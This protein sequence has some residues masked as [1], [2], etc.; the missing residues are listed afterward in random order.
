MTNIEFRKFLSLY[1][2]WHDA[3][4][5]SQEW[6]NEKAW[7]L[8]NKL[9]MPKNWILSS[10]EEEMQKELIRIKEYNFHFLLDEI[11]SNLYQ[12]S[13]D[14]RESYIRELIVEFLFLY[15]Y[16]S[17]LS[18]DEGEIDPLMP[19][20]TIVPG[21]NAVIAL[22]KEYKSTPEKSD[23]SILKYIL[24]CLSKYLGFLE[25]L[26]IICIGIGVDIEHIQEKFG[27]IVR[28]GRNYSSLEID[29][30][31]S[32]DY[33]KEIEIKHKKESLLNKTDTYISITHS[34][35]E[36]YRNFKDIFISEDAYNKA[37][38]VLGEYFDG[39][40]PL[41]PSQYVQIMYSLQRFG[42][43]KSNTR[44]S[45]RELNEIASLLGVKISISYANKLQ[46][47]ETNSISI[48]L[49]KYRS[50]ISK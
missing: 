23:S 43:T 47:L 7:S 19:V 45:G 46:A 33:V 4:K 12:M 35:Q 18:I 22:W 16:F 37:L 2:R 20:A 17:P 41:D 29:G 38:E 24:A 10:N 3:V 48:Q 34:E 15:Q 36:A 6:Y 8:L 28:K 1:D 39:T 9:P 11:R 44:F 27:V 5:L 21:K 30:G 13:E 32:I 31:F 14:T 25:N 42:Y 50:N 49:P 26:D 40:Y